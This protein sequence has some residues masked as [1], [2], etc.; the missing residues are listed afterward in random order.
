MPESYD[1]PKVNH[2]CPPGRIKDR[3]T[4]HIQNA[5]PMRTHLARCTISADDIWLNVLTFHSSRNRWESTR[6]RD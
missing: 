5:R 2:A 6:A 4:H 3:E 1:E